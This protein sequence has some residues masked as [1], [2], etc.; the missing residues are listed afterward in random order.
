MKCAFFRLL[1]VLMVVS[2]LTGCTSISCLAQS[3]DGH[4]Q[5]MTARKDVVKLIED[6]ST[7]KA[8][9]A[10]LASANAIRQFAVHELALPDNNSYRRLLAFR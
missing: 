10:R 6:P 5:M 1:A 2:D 4:L 9:R 3:V 7:P 8:L